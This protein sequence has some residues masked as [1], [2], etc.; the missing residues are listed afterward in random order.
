MADP[1]LHIK[2]S[3]YFEVPKLLYPYEYRTAAQFPTVWISL[4]PKFQ[5]WEADRLLA[6][7]TAI[8]AGLPSNKQ[9]RD[10]WHHWVHADHANFAKLLKV[11]L[12]EKYQA[13][14]AKFKDWKAAEL[15]AANEKKDDT[16]EKGKR[17]DFSD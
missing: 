1:V 10:D 16:I 4:D 7:L 14:V 17:Y 2:D 9:V 13:H 12:E 8:D 15:Q 11:F 5:D 3:Y 6:K